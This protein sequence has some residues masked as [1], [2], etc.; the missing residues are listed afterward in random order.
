MDM[1]IGYENFVKTRVHIR[2]YIFKNIKISQIRKIRTEIL[3][4]KLK[5][6]QTST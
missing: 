2:I 5:N 1:S 6:T 4:D 3:Y